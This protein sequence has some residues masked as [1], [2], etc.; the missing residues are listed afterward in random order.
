VIDALRRSVSASRSDLARLTGLSRTT[1]AAAVTDLQ[2]RGLVVERPE[3]PP[4]EGSRG[5]P[6]V[7]LRLD[8]SAGGVLGVDLGHSHVRVVV[9]D[10]AA[11]VLA[12]RFAPVDVDQDADC[13]LDTGAR[14]AEE[15]LE[16]SGL[17]RLRVV[18]AGLG[19]PG[20]VD[21]NRG[22]IG[23][24][25]TLPG[26][27]G[28]GARDELERRLGGIHVEVD[29]DANLGALGEASFGAGKGF[30]DVV[31]VKVATGIG[32]GLVLDG[33]LHRGATGIAGELGH[34]S[35]RPDGVLCTCGNRGCLQTV[36]AAAPLLAVLQDAHGAGLT[37]PDM[38]RLAAAGDLAARR[39]LN[40]GGRDI[41]RALADLCNHV[42]PA[43]VVVGGE[44]ALAGEPL[45]DGIRDAIDRHALPGAAQA[46]T[47]IPGALGERAEVLGAV[48]L[49]ITD[50]DRLASAGL[51]ALHGPAP[52]G[53]PVGGLAG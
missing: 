22:T 49:V 13:A 24:S 19:L 20:P 51:A 4:A 34:V 25:I 53:A 43:A 8:P 28:F 35:V 5:R 38:L 50:T 9:T 27:S 21:R 17:D 31:Y 32:A 26:W 15:A 12:E 10:L 29:N 46:V 37:V 33:V 44:L 48:A 2:A 30:A 7:M 14:L 6:P 18:G 3:E 52:L 42:N 45:L 1:V 16:E 41:G 23:T 47:V 39:V 40:D 36:A 11:D